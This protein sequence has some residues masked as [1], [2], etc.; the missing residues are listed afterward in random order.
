M[1]HRDSK[2]DSKRSGDACWRVAVLVMLFPLALM[3]CAASMGSR[4]SGPPPPAARVP[5]ATATSEAGRSSP[6]PAVDDIL[7]GTWDTGPYST[8]SSTGHDQWEFRVRFY[9]EAGVPFVTMVAWDPAGG[10]TPDG[11]D[12]GPYQI[13]PNNELGIASA[14]PPQYVT[15]YSY[16]VAGNLLTLTWLRNDPR[17]PDASD[18]SGS[19]TTIRLHRQ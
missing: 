15:I 13:L 16:S 7:T 2:R 6:T 5:D 11:G 1:R 18:T 4:A 10:A 12:H 3:G 17:G 19:F 14:D 8:D 9:H